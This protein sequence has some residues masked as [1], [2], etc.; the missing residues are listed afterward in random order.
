MKRFM[1][2]FEH[3]SSLYNQ[4]DLPLSFGVLSLSEHPELGLRLGVTRIPSVLFLSGG[5]VHRQLT[6]ETRMDWK[7]LKNIIRRGVWKLERAEVKRSRTQA[8][9]ER[10][11]IW[12]RLFEFKL[13]LQIMRFY[14]TRN[15]CFM[16]DLFLR[17]RIS[18][19]CSIGSKTAD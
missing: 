9:K 6:V 18:W 10:L 5:K 15:I 19:C 1:A 11:P 13:G 4:D 8:V 3:L 12:H 14:V 16:S 2:F 7:A 17:T